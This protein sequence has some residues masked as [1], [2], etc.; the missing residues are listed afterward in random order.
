MD[1]VYI[2]AQFNEPVQPDSIKGRLL[3][4]SH[5]RR[6]IPTTIRYDEDTMTAR[7]IP[8]HHI[9]SGTVCEMILDDAVDLAGNPMEYRYKWRFMEA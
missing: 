7:F 9:P 4:V 2:T 6:L 1:P 5:H 3:D 8:T